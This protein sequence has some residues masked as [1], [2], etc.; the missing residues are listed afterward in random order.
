MTISV[1][2][3]EGMVIM[4]IPTGKVCRLSTPLGQTGPGELR[5]HFKNAGHTIMGNYCRFDKR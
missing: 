3:A 4:T 1:T 5:S 2:P